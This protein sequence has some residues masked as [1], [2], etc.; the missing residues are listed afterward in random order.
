M[1]STEQI[2]GEMLSRSAS[3]PA[4]GP[5]SRPAA[6]L[7]RWYHGLK[8][9]RARVRMEDA[10]LFAEVATFV[11]GDAAHYGRRVPTQAPFT[12]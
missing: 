12:A 6:I 7:Q 2:R 1:D 5:G 8:G 10:V 9:M 11:R 4:V 3:R